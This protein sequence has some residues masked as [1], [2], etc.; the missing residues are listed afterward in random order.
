[1]DLGSIAAV[2]AIDASKLCSQLRAAGLQHGVR[3]YGQRARGTV[4][5]LQQR[6]PVFSVARV[7]IQ[8]TQAFLM[9]DS[10][11]RVLRPAYRQSQG[12]TQGGGGA[13]GVCLN[14]VTV[15]SPPRNIHHHG[16]V[17]PVPVP[18]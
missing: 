13:Q 10:L 4:A 1:M 6:I 16:S 3:I 8:G 14:F 2:R 12:S 11:P 18:C 7:A 5:G 9:S 15:G 17:W